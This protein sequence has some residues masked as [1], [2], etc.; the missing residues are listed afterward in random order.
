MAYSMLKDLQYIII[1]NRGC[2]FEVFEREKEREMF[3]LVWP[4]I[5][6]PGNSVGDQ[7]TMGL[8]YYTYMY[9]DL[10]VFE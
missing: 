6:K 7:R 9:I 4:T 5:V 8:F 2:H 10:Y 1:K 3:S